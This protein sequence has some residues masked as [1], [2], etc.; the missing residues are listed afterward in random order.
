MYGL[1]RREKR[2]K[3]SIYS[4]MIEKEY[5]TIHIKFNEKKMK[6]YTL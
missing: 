4:T 2:A 3:S 6:I 5:G 1:M